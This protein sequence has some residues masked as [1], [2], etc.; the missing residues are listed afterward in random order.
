MQAV[1]LISIFTLF[2]SLVTGIIVSGGKNVEQLQR[3]YE[4]ET[5]AWFQRIADVTLNDLTPTNLKAGIV[6]GKNI[7]I[8]A[9]LTNTPELNTLKINGSLPTSDAWRQPITGAASVELRE[10]NQTALGS[11]QA[12][13]TAIALI[14]GGPNGIVEEPLATRLA[15]ISLTNVNVTGLESYRSGDDIVLT[16]TDE[17]AQQRTWQNLKMRVDRIGQVAFRHYQAQLKAYQPRLSDVYEA[18]LTS[19]TTTD[20]S[21]QLITDPNAPKFLNLNLTNNIIVLGVME[22]FEQLTEM[23]LDRTRFSLT[24]TTSVDGQTLTLIL[25]NDT[26]GGRVPTPWT[27][28]DYKLRL[29]GAAN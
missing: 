27:N 8:L 16:F 22:D 11:V 7:N 25:G 10:L 15:T 28:V 23:R 20:L 2:L 18:N 26:T 17:A 6:V 13:V 1:L 19:G 24:A 21:T 5:T 29:T 14:S 4:A 12:P 9:W 3:L